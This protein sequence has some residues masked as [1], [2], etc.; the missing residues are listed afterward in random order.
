MLRA[1]HLVAAPVRVSASLEVGGYLKTEVDKKP[2][3]IPMSVVA[4]FSYDEHRIDDGSSADHRLAVR[5]YDDASAT[6]K[7]ADKVTKPQLRDDRRLIAITAGKDSVNI[8]SPRGPLSREELD[9]IDIPGN[10]L[11]LDELLP[12][13]AIPK[14]H[15]WK[16]SADALARMLGLEAV[17]HTEIDCQLVEVKDGVAEITIEGTLGGAINGVA[18]D[19]DIK[20]KLKLDIDRHAPTSLILAIKE[21]RGISNVTPGLDVVAKLKLTMTPVLESKLL[22]S[23]LLQ[24]AKLPQSDEAPPLEYRSDAKGY[25]FLYDRRWH[26]TRDEPDLVVMRL[27]DR[28]DLIAQCNVAPS[29]KLIDKPVELEKFQA[30]VQSG[31]GKMFGRFEKASE[32]GSDSGLRILQAVAV[33]KAEDLPIQ[34]RYYLVHDHQGRTLSIV[35]TL[36]APLVEQFKD[37]D[38]PILESVEF[39][40]PKMAAAPSGEEK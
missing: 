29:S 40:E 28:G 32:R 27:M 7:V 26:I 14:G 36:E 30:D 33:G 38:K 34:W 21:Q 13:E 37:Q 18:S 4:E 8:S 1:A 12:S 20:G 9:L 15:K 25:R 22:A 39:L 31:L 11:V 6:L 35:Y 5:Y 3:Q 16:P 24:D 10:T 2:Q 19:M 17:G 23:D